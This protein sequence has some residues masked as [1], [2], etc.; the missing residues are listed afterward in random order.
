MPDRKYVMSYVDVM[1]LW[2][3]PLC[4]SWAKMSLTPPQYTILNLKI[5]VSTL[6]VIEMELSQLIS[7]SHT[8]KTI[9]PHVAHEQRRV[10]RVLVPEILV[11]MGPTMQF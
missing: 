4:G 6:T 7:S 10:G 11:S 9:E 8:L 3:S 5:F 2:H 1:T